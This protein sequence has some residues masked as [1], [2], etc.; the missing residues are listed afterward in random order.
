M[1]STRSKSHSQRRTVYNL[2]HI[3]NHEVLFGS[4]YVRKAQ[5]M[6]EQKMRL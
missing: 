4:M 5:E 1:M 3:L 2:Y 6:I